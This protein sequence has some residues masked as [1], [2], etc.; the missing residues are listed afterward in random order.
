VGGNVMGMFNFILTP[1]PALKRDAAEARRPLAS[2]LYIRNFNAN[3]FNQFDIGFLV[4]F[5][6]SQQKWSICGDIKN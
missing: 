1:N 3:I 2:T 6:T 5:S 4:F